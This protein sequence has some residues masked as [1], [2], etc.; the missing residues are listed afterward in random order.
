[1]K[2]TLLILL[3]LLICAMP[4]MANAQVGEKEDV[5]VSGIV[6]SAEDGAPLIGVVVM[7]SAGGGISA[8]DDGSYSISVPAGTLLTF[9]A[10]SYQT[11]EYI[12]PEGNPSVTFN[13]SMESDSQL[14]EET[15][16]VAYGVRKKGTITGSVSSVKSE[17]I[18]STPTAAFDQA[19]QGQVP[20]LTVMASTGEPSVATTMVIRGTNSINSGTA[21]LYILDGAAISASEFNAINPSDIES[22]SVLKDASST[23]I[24]GARASNG[25]IV[26]TTKR[27]RMADKPTISFRAQLGV[28][29]VADGQWNLMD[30]EQRIAYEKEIGIDA[31]KDYGLLSQTNVNWA[32]VVYNDAALLQNYELSVSGATEKTNYYI[33]GAYY[34]QEGVAIGSNFN[35]YSLRVNLEQRAA[36]WLTVGTNTMLNYQGIEQ[37]DDGQ[38]SV[39]TPISAAQFMLPYWNPYNEDGSIAKTGDTWNGDGVNPIE[40][41]E[42]NPLTF[43]RYKV[44][45]SIFAEARPIEGLSIRSQF[46][47]DYTHTTGYG[48]SY[49]D[50]APNQEQGQAMRSSTD[51]M[52]LSVTNTIGYQFDIDHLHSF[53]FMVGQEGINYHY[54]AF[55]VLS[56][57]QNNHY[58]TNLTTGSR[59]SSWGDTTDDDYGFLSFFARAEYN[60]ASK[61]YLE[62]SGRADASSRFGR[63]GRWAGFGSVGLMW[64]MLNEDFMAPSRSWL[65]FAQIALSSGT[66]GN[67]EIPNYNHLALIGN[68]GDYM[69]TP[70]LAPISQGNENLHW[71][72]TWTTNLAFHFGFWNRLNVD[73][74]LYNKYTYNMLMLVPQSYSDNGFGSN[75]D[76]VGAMVN[77]GAEINLTGTALQIGD[78]SWVLNANVSYNHN[79]ITELYGGVDEYEMASTSLKLVVGHDSGEF[80]LNR[81]AGVNPANGDALW[82]TKDGEI[83]NEL[84]DE[85]RVMVGKSFNA[86]WAGGF[87]TTFSWKGLSLSAQFSWVA[88]RWVINNDR[89]YQE[90]NGRFQTYNQSVKLLDRWK[91]PGDI[92]DTPRHGEFMEFDDRL[93][94][95]ASFLRLKNLMLSYQ[96]PSNVIQKSGFIEGLRVY[97]QA[98]NLL[99]FTNFSG[100][101]PEG[102]GN[103]YIAQYPMSRQ[104]TFGLD[105]TF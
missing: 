15:V 65:T 53:N 42:N 62:L 51:G 27:G 72:S 13:V 43:K 39:V 19:L 50:F 18:E 103:I 36:K 54:E 31:G 61:Y 20:G 91:E 101:D 25:V 74:E 46:T 40:W 83:T 89:Y 33:S 76:N 17:K 7:S 96:I 99:T 78:F 24:Y 82:Y 30:T 28:S 3:E 86:P 68:A 4:V 55:N 66:A 80:F 57:G 6:T 84:R 16:V 94:E 93:L 97:F 95:D 34:D 45:S 60:Y 67:S 92:S 8:S 38:P 63:S 47:V 9:H 41:L 35:R 90:S 49:P 70:G 77:R 104:F 21:P 23:S 44:F 52:T 58:L 26:I 88:D 75:W 105:L 73:L 5:T 71:E 12:V 85:D 10:I 56:E 48:K 98:Q 69:G 2:N 64:N 102:V 11:V 1:M 22:I 100:L 32:D 37:A 81:F 14:L 87:G 29:N 59:V 79:R